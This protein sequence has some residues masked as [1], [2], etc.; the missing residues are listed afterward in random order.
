MKP[1]EVRAKTVAERGKL[2]SE[3]RQNFFNLKVK[4]ATG[5]LEKNHQLKQM[6]RDIARLLTIQ[7]EKR[8]GS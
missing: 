3:L 8:K 6:R 5:Q 1:T 7:H 4:M 2:L